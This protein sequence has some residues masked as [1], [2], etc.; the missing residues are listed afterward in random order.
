MTLGGLPP[1]P[2]TPRPLAR[3]IGL[4]TQ[5]FVSDVAADAFQYAR[6][7]SS[8]TSSG[9]PMNLGA[10]PAPGAAGG[11]PAAGAAAGDKGKA[12]SLGAPRPGFGGGG[13]GGGQGRTVLTTEDLGQAVAEYGINLK[14]PEWFR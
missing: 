6:I 7:R 5:K 14:R 10:A 11:A 12:A 8:N 4:A 2:E 9:N 1:P 3:L 13:Q